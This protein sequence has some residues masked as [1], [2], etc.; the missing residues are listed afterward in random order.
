MIL[1]NVFDFMCRKYCLIKD[2]YSK[3]YVS[4]IRLCCLGEGCHCYDL[5]EI[6]FTILAKLVL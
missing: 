2:G 5:G 6:L 1:N 3:F 4:G